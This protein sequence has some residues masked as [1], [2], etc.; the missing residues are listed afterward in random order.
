MLSIKK[1]MVK[2]RISKKIDTNKEIKNNIK[3][4]ITTVNRVMRL[5]K[6]SLIASNKISYKKQGKVMIIFYN[7]NQ[8]KRNIKLKL[9][10][11]NSK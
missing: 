3:G 8:N 4:I 9:M 6:I 1:D 10:K 5:T 7:L 11:Y 2:N